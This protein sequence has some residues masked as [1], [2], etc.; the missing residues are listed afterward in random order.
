MTFRSKLLARVPD[1]LL[2]KDISSVRSIKGGF[3]NS[4]ILINENYL[5]KEYQVQDEAN[6]P[7]YSRFL[8]EKESLLLLKNN[9]FSPKLL[10]FFDQSSKL[11]ITREWIE[12][13][14]ISV[15][16]FQANLDKIIDGLISIHKYRTPASED[17]C[18]FDVISRYL[19]VYDRLTTNNLANSDL[20]INLP[21]FQTV[22]HYFD[23][24]ISQLRDLDQLPYQVRLH[25]DLVLSNIIF[26]PKQ[27][28]IT[29]IDWEYSTLGDILIDLSYLLTQ[30]NLPIDTQNRLKDCY[31]EQSG[32]KLDLTILNFYCDLMNLM[33]ALWYSIHTFRLY[34]NLP[35]Y[36]EPP[37][38]ISESIKS[39]QSNFESLKLL[40]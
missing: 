10:S 14:P 24:H 12:G 15:G 13:N 5:I 11:Y 32:S 27:N 38:F 40:E 36:A 22:N 23:N 18:Y 30:N 29:F 21:S 3:N 8:R 33:S 35:E 37:S 1:I 20:F 16:Q 39:A 7:V 9:S 34:L 17:F 2:P 28:N 25:G 31:M 19:K 4:N 26:N 6:D